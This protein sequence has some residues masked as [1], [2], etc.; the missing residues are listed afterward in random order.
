M[1][2]LKL[3][4]KG[5]NSF[6]TNQVIDFKR[7]SERGL[8]GI[9][10]KTGSGKSTVLD[11]IYLAL[12][13]RIIRTK[14]LFD[15][16]N[17]QCD[18][19]VVKLKF[20]STINGQDKVFLIERELT[21][22]VSKKVKV[23]AN[24]FETDEL[25]SFTT[26]LASG[27]DEVTNKVT[28]I[29]GYGAEE[30]KQCIALPQG[31]YARFLRESPVNKVNTIAKIF[32]LEKYGTALF[33]KTTAELTENEKRL[34]FINGV[35]S[36]NGNITENDIIAIKKE[37]KLND[38][39][40][41]KTSKE[42]EKV[43][44]DY[45]EKQKDD[46]VEAEKA[47]AKVRLDKISENLEEME[48]NKKKLNILELSHKI[49]PTYS[50]LL[51]AREAVNT[52]EARINTVSEELKKASVARAE[53]EGEAQEQ[54]TK[55]YL[56]L[57]SLEL[58]KKLLSEAINNKH[59]LKRAENRRASL[60]ETLT[61]YREAL[62]EKEA[63]NNQ[64]TAQIEELNNELASLNQKAET[65]NV[66]LSV[67]SDARHYE[68]LKSEAEI[69]ENHQKTIKA[70]LDEARKKRKNAYKNLEDLDKELNGV[71]EGIATIANRI[72]EFYGSNLTPEESLSKCTEDY[73][74]ICFYGNELINLNAKIEK[75]NKDIE[76]FN[77]AL[78]EN[79]DAERELKEQLEEVIIEIRTLN[80]KHDKMLFNRE[81]YFGQNLIGFL[82]N[83][84]EDGSI[85]P[86]CSNIVDSKPAMQNEISLNSFDFELETIKH[87][88]VECHAKKEDIVSRLAGN[89]S[90]NVFLE[91]QIDGAKK[92]LA[93]MQ[94]RKNEIGELAPLIKNKDDV[95]INNQINLSKIALTNLTELTRSLGEQNKVKLNKEKLCV[96]NSAFVEELDKEIEIY[97]NMQESNA[98]RL[99]E[100][101]IESLKLEEEF[102]VD[103]ITTKVKNYETKKSDFEKLNTE[104]NS[105]VD[106]I[107]TVMREKEKTEASFVE[108]LVGVR[109]YENL[110]LGVDNEINELKAKI[111][112]VKVEISLEEDLKAASKK[113]DEFK[114]KL[115]IL[116]QRELKAINDESKLKIE[117][118]NLLS[119]FTYRREQ[120]KQIE[121][122]YNSMLKLAGITEADLVLNADIENI[123]RLEEKI[124]A[125]ERELTDAQNVYNSLNKIAPRVL[126]NSEYIAE[127]LKT[128]ETKY[129][130]LSKKHD[131]L[132]EK[133][134]REQET[135]TK[136]KYFLGEKQ[137][138]TENIETLK[139]LHAS[140]QGGKLVSF[141]TEEYITRITEK[142]NVVL[143]LL[144]NGRYQ[145]VFEDDY[146][147]CDNQNGGTIRNINTLS[148]GE[149]FLASFSIAIAIAQMM[150]E[151]KRK[152]LEFI[153]LDEGFGTL[154]NECIDMVMLSLQK[155]K[156]D[157]FII[158]LITHEEIIKNRVVGKIEVEKINGEVG[159]VVKVVI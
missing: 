139:E 40:L 91:S 147:V 98:K 41:A 6:V 68:K 159:S 86:I 128:L 121:E 23:K 107:L 108:S 1:K 143:E 58:N 156:S 87:Q 25:D 21:R 96:K 65:I 20:V 27:D 46:I 153:F 59:K 113:S 22:D 112:S 80:D 51:A 93:S 114:V 85:C 64:I 29:I 134:A 83:E 155:L 127:N 100:L 36:E 39:E 99:A 66:P 133:L 82:K 145:L 4:I 57:T 144:T 141:I 67:I 62:K 146:V 48:E 16:I 148:G 70:K 84:V 54:K 8:F 45:I 33:E 135:L 2:P 154:D 37:I 11:A 118:A 78:S 90:N 63:K 32:K 61:A 111:D 136:V 151:F 44:Q 76:M 18:K 34:S 17:L 102:G 149:T 125:F 14:K 124:K 52:S 55:S 19:G 10:G 101:N 72:E 117:K 126:K 157:T 106:T 130:T 122:E 50:Y 73:N 120:L 132:L 12:Y 115:E 9:F 15:V 38:A 5:I 123:T 24:L 47:E 95:E 105:L 81:K 138:V 104:R 28:E 97:E 60:F 94:A 3:E 69:F 109:N 129:I 7:L 31:E 53:V 142:A 103:D 89:K 119:N 137:A 26:L 75:K 77:K 43:K 30:F 35:L 150:V 79:F 116:T 71:K 131:Y 49:Y 158:G 140:I 110:V 56:A 42:Y 152:K 88:L 13:G 92:E 74:T